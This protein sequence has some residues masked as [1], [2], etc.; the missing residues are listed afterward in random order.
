MRPRPT[1]RGPGLTRMS[2]FAR[3][4]R[5]CGRATVEDDSTG[6]D[7][8]VRS[9][10]H[11][12]GCV[13]TPRLRASVT[14]L[15]LVALPA[16]ALAMQPLPAR[17]LSAQPLAAHA[18]PAPSGQDGVAYEIR[19]RIEQFR[20]TG[21]LDVGGARI[22][23]VGMLAGL[24]EQRAFAPGLDR[25]GGVRRSAERHR[26]HGGLWPR[27]GGLPPGIHPVPRR[28]GACTRIGIIGAMRPQRGCPDE[29]A[30]PGNGVA[31]SACG[32]QARGST[33]ASS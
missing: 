7:D 32:V 5:R 2:A 22:T 16:P 27:T 28:A 26:R 19:Q 3:S 21:S 6:G 18:L 33:R 9:R 11:V 29:T 4:R 15:A 20:E 10:G 13:F 23:R 1:G 25:R 30:E 8:D 12:Q 14:L 17:P 31:F 24:Y